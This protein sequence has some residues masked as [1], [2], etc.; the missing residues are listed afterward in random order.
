MF[1][2]ILSLLLIISA[3]VIDFFTEKKKIKYITLL[4]GILGC[5]INIFENYR[6][7][8]NYSESI[9][10]QI[11]SEEDLKI[12]K[13]KLEV[14]KKEVDKNK[15]Y[16][17]ISKLNLKGSE[18]DFFMASSPDNPIIPDGLPKILYGAYASYVD[19]K[20][21]NITQYFCDPSSL[22]K[23]KEA[24][25]FN[26]DFPFSYFALAV[27]GKNI[28]ENLRKSLEILKITTQINGR[29]KDHDTVLNDIQKSNLK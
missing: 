25:D 23:Y 1:L 22:E 16:E 26:P 11:I 7:E 3:L 29:H 5:T 19:E 27:C 12:T 8:K 9:L 15:K 2:N 6:N 13:L 10:R 28:Q 4:L 17:H 18:Q 14:T 24:I 20:G 21:Q